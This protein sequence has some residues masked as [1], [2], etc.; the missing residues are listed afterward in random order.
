MESCRDVTSSRKGFAIDRTQPQTRING[1][2]RTSP[3]R[4]I[5]PEG[6]QL[7]VIPTEE[8]IARA[9]DFGLD[10]VE[11]APTE[12]PPVCRIMD[13]GKYKYEKNKKRAGAAHTHQTKTK[14]IRLRP[15]TGEHDIEFKVKQAMGFLQHKDKVLVSVIFKG[16]EMAHVEEGRRIME[17]VIATL[18]E[19]G[20]IESPPQQQGKKMSCTIAPK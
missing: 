4:V 10:L 1:Q 12:K 7:G 17:S 9:R 3:V 16:R 13:F 11:V 15:K 20:K 2:I 19:F 14:E 6:K 8:A 5:D 18:S